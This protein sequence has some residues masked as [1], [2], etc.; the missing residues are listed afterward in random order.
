MMKTF[1]SGWMFVKPD[2]NYFKKFLQ[3]NRIAIAG[4]VY[5][6]KVLPE[7][8]GIPVLDFDDASAVIKPGD[9]VLDVSVNPE[10]RGPLE[11]FFD[12]RG[13]RRISVA[14]FLDGLITD[15]QHDALV[16][17]VP[18]VKASDI[19]NLKQLPPPGRFDAHFFDFESYAVASRLDQVFRHSDWAQ[20][21]P[22]DRDD[23]PANALLTILLDLHARSL[24]RHLHV[25][26]TPRIFLDAILKL[27]LHDAKASFTVGVS[28]HAFAELGGRA[29]FY[30]RSLADCIV[31]FASAVPESRAIV[32]AGSPDKVMAAHAGGPRLSAICFMPRSIIDY[33]ALNNAL[34]DGQYKILLRQPDTIAQNLLAAVLT[35]AL[36]AS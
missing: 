13:V 14:E 19:R 11:A 30:R 12:A 7:V 27:R 26:D 4:I 28:D 33:V 18:G 1:A 2:Q 31:P 24:V 8:E 22:F 21:I 25:L 9:R 32:L 36:F 35:P 5:P 17:P 10:L 34:G 3:S 6:K 20:L 15:D 29:E 23:T 16:L